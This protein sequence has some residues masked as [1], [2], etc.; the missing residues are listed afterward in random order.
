[1]E[2][3]HLSVSPTC[4]VPLHG[5]PDVAV[6]VVVARQ[7]Q[8][9]GAR[10]SHRGDAA[11]DV[12]VAVDAELLVCA[13]V[14]QPAG[15]VIRACSKSAAIG[16]E[17]QRRNRNRIGLVDY[18][19]A[20]M[21]HFSTNTRALSLSKRNEGTRSTHTGS[22]DVRLVTC[23]G[24]PAHAVPDVPQ[25][26]RSIAG[27]WH[28]GAQVRRQGQA[29]DVA[30]VAREHSGL[31]T[32]LDVPHRTEIREQ[33]VSDDLLRRT[34]L[35]LW[36]S[37]GG[38]SRTCDDLIVINEAATWQVTWKSRQEVLISRL[39][40]FQVPKT[41][42]HSK[43]QHNPHDYP[44]TTMPNNCYSIFMLQ[45]LFILLCSDYQP[46]LHLSKVLTK[47]VKYFTKKKNF[48]S[49]TSLSGSF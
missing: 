6:K 27:P 11:D 49:K 33:R 23:E 7:Q 42:A 43:V 21:P 1:M 5:V 17:L 20:F 41:L 48:T 10:E 32:R 12:V 39:F 8:A 28:E 30:G 14:K 45:H 38:V 44:S 31:L 47:L 29:H 25:L 13:Q 46:S 2:P 37:P 26:D 3:P 40:L 22:I 18:L 35:A 24:L 36:D 4:S 9:A 19:S 16:K 34:G 15:G